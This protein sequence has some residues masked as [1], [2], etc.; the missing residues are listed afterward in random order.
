MNIELNSI[1]QTAGV[2][3]IQ[4]IINNHIYVGS[5][6]DLYR[7]NIRHFSE[8][9]LGHHYNTH[10]QRAYNKYGKDNFEFEVLIT[11]HPD[12]LVWYEQQFVD[13]WKPEYNQRLKV[14][15]NLRVKR[16]EEYKRKS[17]ES[18]KG[19][20][21]N[22]TWRENIG[23]ANRMKPSRTKTGYKGVV[24]LPNGRYKATT[25]LNGKCIYLGCFSTPEE[26]HMA[27]INKQSEI[28]NGVGG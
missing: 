5:T 9:K 2:Y 18:R 1:N 12:M 20:Y 16:S 6:I 10:L 14:D 17:S 24:K 22:P 19:W 11:C 25:G 7:R 15:T 4:N 27:Y 26:A 8:L 23:I 28:L 13:Q 3:Q 21:I